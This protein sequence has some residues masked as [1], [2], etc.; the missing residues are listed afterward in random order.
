MINI[1]TIFEQSEYWF[2]RSLSSPVKLP[3]TE[4]DILIG[5]NELAN[6]TNYNSSVLKLQ[7]NLIYLYS[8]SKYSN[9]DLPVNYKGWLGTKQTGGN[10]LNVKIKNIQLYNVIKRDN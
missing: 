5:V 7:S 3:Y 6:G 1:D 2:N 9:P 4:D 10:N 8:V